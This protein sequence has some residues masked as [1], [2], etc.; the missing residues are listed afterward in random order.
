MKCL[1]G[2]PKLKYLCREG[3]SENEY[4]HNTIPFLYRSEDGSYVYLEEAQLLWTER[5]AI[6]FS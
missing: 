6:G 3:V 1:T 5:Q 2:T 4:H